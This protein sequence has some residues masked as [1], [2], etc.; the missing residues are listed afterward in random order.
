[1]SKSLISCGDLSSLY[2][3]IIYSV[4]FKCLK[5]F[6][7]TFNS[8]KGDINY[9]LFFFESELNHHILIKSLFKYIGFIVFGLIF[10]YFTNKGKNNKNRTQA[11]KNLIHN[12][13]P[14]A[15]INS[16][17]N[18]VFICSLYA[19]FL[20]LIEISYYIG[21][22]DFD[23]WIFNIVFTL[24]FLS[25][26]FSIRIY[27]HQKYSLLFIFSTNLMLLI[28]KSFYPRKNNAYDTTTKLFSYKLLSI[29][30]FIIYI[31]NSFL[32]SFS[33]VLGKVLMELRYI[34]PYL[35]VILVGIIGLIFTSIL[36]TI[37]SIYKCNK[38]NF[39]DLCNIY[40]IT[41]NKNE[42]DTYFDSIPL[43]FSNLKNKSKNS[44]A[45]FW[46]EVTIMNFLNM[47]I[48]FMVFNYEI[49]LIY[50]LNPIYILISDCLYYGTL[51][52]LNFLLT[53]ND[54]DNSITKSLLVIIADLLGFLGYL[55]YVEIIELKFFGINK[56]LR[57]EISERAILD[58]AENLYP[59]NDDEEEEEEEE[60]EKESGEKIY[61]KQGTKEKKED[62]IKEIN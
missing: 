8:I 54:A 50:Y 38:D 33:R 49:L 53:L 15:P 18:L 9:G 20:E 43:Y 1:M 6:I 61:K 16:I 37:T 58:L 12:V 39:E 46:I 42:T 5:D 19:L 23:L 35:I 40:D 45:K 44:K 60:E 14:K 31:V 56:N 10:L 32:I 41:Y 48:N 13:K 4:I 11:T 17:L 51:S 25:R 59:K 2:L 24:F 28:L 47:F 55:I 29:I 62:N 57:K 36:I 3:Y 52:L 27:K 26:Y 34:S 22:H 30:I 7:L 21:F